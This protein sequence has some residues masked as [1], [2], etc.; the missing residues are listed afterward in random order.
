ME[1]IRIPRIA[2]DTCRK[3]L[4]KGRSIGFVPT[5]GALH[6]GHLSLIRRSRSE[7]DI[8]AGSIFVNPMQFGPSEDFDKYPRDIENDIRKMRD[9]E[10]D[11][12]FMPD[13]SVIYP[14]RFSTYINIGELSGKLCGRFRPGHFTGVATIVSKLFNIINPT[15]AYFGQK[16]FQQTVTIKKMVKDL[17]FN[18]D[19]VVCP[20][21]REPDG[22]AMS[23]RN[24]YLNEE[25]RKAASVIFKCLTKASDMIKSG[26]INPEQAKELMLKAI[27]EEALITDT[28]YASVYDPE[29]L[30][31]ITEMSGD[32]LLAVAVQVGTTRLIDNVLINM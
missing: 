26:I 16:D 31:E 1:I 17:N 13:R 30:D 21:V 10:V 27:S 3:H 12:L 29:T 7:N 4:L 5:M 19:V 32:V 22:L 23:S 2:L 6:E 8:T 15:R 11:I 14:E 9:E 25:Q 28:D 24:T 18:I 20:T